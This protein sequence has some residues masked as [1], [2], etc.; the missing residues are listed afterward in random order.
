MQFFEKPRLVTALVF[1]I[2]TIVALFHMETFIYLHFFNAFILPFFFGF[3]FAFYYVYKFILSDLDKVQEESTNEPEKAVQVEEMKNQDKETQSSPVKEEEKVVAVK[4]VIEEDAE[5][6][7][8]SR[9]SEKHIQVIHANEVFTD[10]DPVSE[11]TLERIDLEPVVANT[12]ISHRQ[13]DK[14]QASTEALNLT[15]NEKT[16][17]TASPTTAHEPESKKEA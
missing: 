1:F 2:Q 7:N 16:V 5:K 3:P 11:E 14:E 17:E 15:E 6:K 10:E 9:M 8:A 12:A 4:K 13:N